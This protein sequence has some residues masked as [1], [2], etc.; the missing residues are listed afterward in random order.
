[1]AKKKQ[2]KKAVA[3]KRQLQKAQRPGVRLQEARQ[4]MEAGEL[5][6]A[7]NLAEDAHRALRASAADP[8]TIQQAQRLLAELHFRLAE[9]SAAPELR[10]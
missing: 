9:A 6:K 1:M 5:A 2:T 4:A 3:Y 7:L 10:L 8:A